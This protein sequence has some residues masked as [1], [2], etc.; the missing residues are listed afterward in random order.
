MFEK[1]ED[2]AFQFRHPQNSGS[3]FQKRSSGRKATLL[4]CEKGDFGVAVKHIESLTSR[5]QNGEEVYWN[6]DV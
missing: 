6:A 2:S 4:G 5:Y 1:A 3:T